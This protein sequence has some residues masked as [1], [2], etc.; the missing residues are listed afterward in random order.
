MFMSCTLR[1]GGLARVAALGSTRY[2]KKSELGCQISRGQNTRF[3]IYS[4]NCR[5]ETESGIKID[6]DWHSLCIPDFRMISRFLLSSNAACH[7]ICRSSNM[8]AA[9]LSHKWTNNFL[10]AVC[11]VLDLHMAKNV[12][13]SLKCGSK[14]QREM[15][16]LVQLFSRQCCV[17]FTES[18][19]LENVQRSWQE[20]KSPNDAQWLSEKI[21]FD[22]N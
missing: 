16:R 9:F 8:T 14:H 20:K 22:S 3:E 19:P 17:Y 1:F 13:S 7:L 2:R 5:E 6:W 18:A 15:H 11:L 12:S 4:F 21:Q 10:E